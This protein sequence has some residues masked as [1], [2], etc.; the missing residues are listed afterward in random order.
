M[1][2]GVRFY[3]EVAPAL[4]RREICSRRSAAATVSIKN[5]RR[6]DARR[7]RAVVILGASDARLT[8]SLD[9]ARTQRMKI[10]CDADLHRSAVT[11]W[12]RGGLR[13]VFE[14]AQV[15]FDAL[16]SPSR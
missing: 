9:D 12:P 10:R 8:R 11:A 4:D 7:H 14:L 13:V 6:P 5:L 15:R 16:T 3:L 2:G 1:H